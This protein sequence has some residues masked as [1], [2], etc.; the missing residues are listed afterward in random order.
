MAVRIFLHR[1]SSGV[2]TAWI[3][4]TVLL[5]HAFAQS[6]GY[7]R[8]H[9][10]RWMMGDW[11]MGWFGMV[12]MLLF[13]V[14]VIAGIVIL[15]RWLVQRGGSRDRSIVGAD[16]QAM[17]ILKKR[18]ASGEISKDEFESMKKEILE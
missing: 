1:I 18:Y 15:V 3:L 8:G 16:S 2:L 5:S 9:M 7:T 10:G 11:G 12:F 17:E 4:N 14:L 13:W 6:G